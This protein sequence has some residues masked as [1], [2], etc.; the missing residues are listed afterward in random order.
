MDSK[1]LAE[2]PRI[3]YYKTEDINQL[4]TSRDEIETFLE[5]FPFNFITQTAFRKK[6]DILF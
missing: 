2:I 5:H 6:N 3:A 4:T 1:N